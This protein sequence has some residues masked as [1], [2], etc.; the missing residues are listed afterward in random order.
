MKP[1]YFSGLNGLRAIAA[2]GVLFT[3]ITQGLYLFGLNQHIFGEAHGNKIAIHRIALYCVSIFFGIS[4][5]LITYLLLEEKKRG[6]INIKKF[7]I[8]RML[9]I[10]PLYYLYLILTLLSNYILEV[11][12]DKTQLF[13][14]IFLM[15][16]I[17]FFL[18][19]AIPFVIHYWSLGV[20]EQFY[21]FLPNI[22]KRFQ[23]VFFVTVVIFLA[24][25]TLKLFFYITASRFSISYTM[26][27]LLD[28]SRFQ[29]MMIG[30]LFGIM[31][32]YQNTIFL[33]ISTHIV[34]QLFSWA[35]IFI[36][37]INKYKF[38]YFISHEVITLA[39]CF[40][41]IAQI[42][43]KNRIINLENKA[44][45]FLGKISYGIYVIHPL[46][47]LWLSK[48]IFFSS[49]ATINYIIVYVA[50]IAI[51]ITLSYLSYR[52]FEK[53]FLDFKHKYTTIETIATKNN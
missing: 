52:Y 29:C 25:M 14:Y 8:R 40:I 35:V 46:V 53:R 41:I 24:L 31:F 3:H 17:P 50:C 5:F 51:T 20:E 23:N 13:F 34:V 9:R 12:Y 19:K 42:Q 38:S 32:Y 28:S 22:I 30:V 44:F 18:G 49:H 27:F 47:A 7:Y 10:W 39:T 36:M 11:D 21:L 43:Q 15:A 6:N 37:F 4:G 45:D 33:T 1:I 16:N 48:V 2:L 26:Y